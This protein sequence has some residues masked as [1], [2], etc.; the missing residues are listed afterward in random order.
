MTNPETKPTTN[1][2]IDRC[3]TFLDSIALQVVALKNLLSTLT[4]EP[5]YSQAAE[6]A[7]ELSSVD[8]TLCDMLDWLGEDEDA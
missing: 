4:K 5:R 1:P 7:R 8:E 6:A 3:E 2:D